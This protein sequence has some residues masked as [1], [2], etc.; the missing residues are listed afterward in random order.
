MQ[1]L[2]VRFQRE[3][4]ANR[5]KA[6]LLAGLFL[7]GCCF[8]L[9]M[10]YRALSSAPA[11]TAK[12][13]SSS[14][15]VAASSTAPSPGTTAVA[16]VDNGKFWANLSK[17]L[18]EDAMFQSADVQ[19]LDRDPFTVAE[20]SEPLPVLFAEEPKA[21][22][23]VVVD[24]T[25]KSAPIPLELT[26]TIIGRTRSIARINGQL[27][28]LGKRIQTDG[29][30]FQLTKIESHRVELSSGDQTIELTL[31]RPQLKDV[32]NRGE[33]ESPLQ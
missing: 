16:E 1:E 3:V 2:W 19:R 23:A 28:P 6:G 12:R 10:V 5:Q 14:T 26:G 13:P 24:T 29:K 31:A 30:S 15:P 27:Y 11:H 22:P 9:P 32:L 33:P 18:A 17:S 25:P 8:W 7:F 20:D 4:K 21:A